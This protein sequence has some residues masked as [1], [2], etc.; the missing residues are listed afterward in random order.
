LKKI[1]L[2]TC[3]I[4]LVVSGAAAGI[5]ESVHAPNIDIGLATT[6]GAVSD[7]YKVNVGA[8]PDHEVL[9]SWANMD[10]IAA[11]NI[12]NITNMAAAI[13][14]IGLAQNTLSTLIDTKVPDTY[15]L[16]TIMRGFVSLEPGVHKGSA[17][18]FAAN[19]TVE[20][21]ANNSPSVPMNHVWVINLSEALTVGAGTV[22]KTNIPDDHTATIIWN[23]GTTVTLG[24]GTQFL[25]SAFVGSAFGAATSDVVCGNVYATGALIVGSVGAVEDGLDSTTINEPVACD[26]N[27]DGMPKF[28]IS[29]NEYSF[30][31][32]YAISSSG[33]ADG[34][35]LLTKHNGTQGI[36]VIPMKT[37]NGRAIVYFETKANKEIFS[38]KKFSRNAYYPR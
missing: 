37:G 24:A 12:H 38:Y 31:I 21:F 20:F 4:A 36:K 7:V 17:I 19:S 32:E 2:K 25:G 9:R 16:S 23:V 18:S 29:E 30:G 22:F 1:L 11:E 28:T 15:S 14:H 33:P 13:A 26:T 10:N 6:V 3:L 5:A 35:V 34:T 27:A 8:V